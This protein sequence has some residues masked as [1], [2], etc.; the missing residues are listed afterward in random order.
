MI[1]ASRLASQTATCYQQI[2]YNLFQERISMSKLIYLAFLLLV[3]CASAPE[4]HQELNTS[5]N[6]VTHSYAEMQMQ[7]IAENKAVT[8]VIG[9]ESPIFYFEE[10]KS[11]YATFSLPDSGSSRKLKVITYFSTSY[12]PAAN[13]L[14]PH[15]QLLNEARQPISKESNISLHAGTDFWAGPYYEGE[16]IVP[17]A[18]KAVIIYT[19]ESEKPT[20]YSV[21]ENGMERVVPHAPS[22]K[23]VLE[24]SAP[25]SASYN[26][27]KATIKDSL[28]GNDSQKGDFF[29][30]SKINGKSIE[31]SRSKTLSMNRGRGLSMTPN[32]VERDVSVNF[33]TYTLV[34]RTEYAAPIL[35]LT[36][37]VYEVKGDIQ[38]TL[39][40]DKIY[41][42]RGELR[43]NY[44]AVW[45]E[46]TVA[47][48]IVGNKIEIHGSPALGVFSK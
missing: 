27:S 19:S 46:D 30:V 21:S 48:T 28:S 11:Y 35:A 18:A 32:L 24:L 43:E 33:A 42:V 36:N 7:A 20:L 4:L 8:A 10:G 3:G 44:A 37:P 38:A 34:G 16:L 45:L 9:K 29:Y 23:L 13:I 47:H 41:E 6:Q 39:E 25:Y 5:T 40:K 31:N 26:F 15:F 14:Y 17:A 12:L 1:L 2:F 22:G